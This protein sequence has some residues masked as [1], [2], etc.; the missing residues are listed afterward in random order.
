MNGER[1]RKPSPPLQSPRSRKEIGAAHCAHLPDLSPRSAQL[2]IT[3]PIPGT[4]PYGASASAVQNCSRQFC[5]VSIRLCPP[6]LAASP[7][8]RPSGSPISA[9]ARASLHLTLFQRYPRCCMKLSRRR[10]LTRLSGLQELRVSSR[11]RGV[12]RVRRLR[13]DPGFPGPEPEGGRLGSPDRRVS[14]ASGKACRGS[15][16]RYPAENVSPW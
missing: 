8:L 1:G 14:A 9:G 11:Q 5:R 6:S 13:R 10:R 12:A 16:H 7:C 15:V 3:R 4:R 2:D